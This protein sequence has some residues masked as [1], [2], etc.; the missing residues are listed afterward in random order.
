M[1]VAH[2]SNG[3]GAM[4]RR[5]LLPKLLDRRTSRNLNN[6]VAEQISYGICHDAIAD[7]SEPAT[8]TKD[9]QI[10]QEERNLVSAQAENIEHR[11]AIIRVRS[12]SL[13]AC[14]ELWQPTQESRN[15]FLQPASR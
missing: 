1:N 7:V 2:L 13:V 12:Y 11:R 8:D 14:R 4:T 15:P 3:L 6:Q 9:L 10:Q 5:F